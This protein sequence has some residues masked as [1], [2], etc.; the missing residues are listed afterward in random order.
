MLLQPTF[1]PACFAWCQNAARRDGGPLK[2]CLGN[3]RAIFERCRSC[4][5]HAIWRR[6]TTRPPSAPSARTITSAPYSSAARTTDPET[7]KRFHALHH[8]RGRNFVA[9]CSSC[10]RSA[11]PPAAL[12]R[13]RCWPRARRSPG[14]ATPFRANRPRSMLAG[15]DAR[16]LTTLGVRFPLTP[17]PKKR[18]EVGTVH[19]RAALRASAAT[20][21]R[22]DSA[23]K[24]RLVA[25][26]MF[27]ASTRVG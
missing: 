3:F 22:F 21:L 8:D 4:A 19:S 1:P 13:A 26:L 7:S 5:A 17:P 20:P 11:I 10:T 2:L 14:C 23:S 18:D 24:C 15:R 25:S 9:R 12:R 27:G 16:L 6:R